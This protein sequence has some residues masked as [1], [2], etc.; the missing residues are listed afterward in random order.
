MLVRCPNAASAK[1]ILESDPVAQFQRWLDEAWSA[2]EPMANAMAVATTAPDGTPSVRM[3]LLDQADERGFA[4]QTNL[5]SRKARHLAANPRAAL[6]FF[7]PKLLR[8]GA[9][10]G[11]RSRTYH[12]PRWSALLRPGAPRFRPCCA[13]A[14]ERNDRRSRRARTPV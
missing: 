12:G 9:R 5:D 7:W 2:G 10:H 1:P 13:P 14:A 6:L 8:P 11:Q 4:F 3:V